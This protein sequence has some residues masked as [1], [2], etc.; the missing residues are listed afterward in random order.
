M[1]TASVALLAAVIVAAMIGGSSIAVAQTSIDG[2]RHDL[3][4][5]TG[6]NN[7]IC[8]YCHT[9]HGSETTV[10]APLWNKPASGAT[11]QTYDST[12][13]TTLDG[14]VLGVGSV[15]IACLSCHDGTQAMDTVINGPGRDNFT[16]G[17]AR[18]GSLGGT[19]EI[20]DPT[21]NPNTPL[22]PVANIGTDLTNDHPIGILYGGFDT[23]SGVSDPDFVTP[24]T[25]SIN[26]VT[27]WWVDT[28]EVGAQVG[29]REK[30]DM[31]L[32]RRD[33]GGTFQPFVECASCHDPHNPVNG[34]FLRIA[35]DNSD[36][37]LACH[38][39]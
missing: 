23:G 1:K 11:Y 12:I 6:D 39:K 32:Y 7:E 37:C 24:A 36:V 25:A 4:T 5:G 27:Q 33:N 35:N 29:V 8:V 3:A 2:S 26:T 20:D 22:N 30:T 38:V 31:I 19:G 16:P 9:P 18:I 28:A 15:S 34:T 14:A 21:G 13:S 10:E 17:G